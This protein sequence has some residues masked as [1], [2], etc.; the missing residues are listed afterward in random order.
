MKVYRKLSEFKPQAKAI[1]T[2]GTFDGV[3]IGHQKLLSTINDLAKAEDGES[4]LLTFSPHPRLVLFPEDNDLKL[5]STLDE[6]IERLRKSGLD[7]LIV[8][9]FTIDFS[10]ITA[11]DYVSEILVNQLGV[12]KLVIGYDHHFG[13]NREGNLEYLKKVAPE[14][15]FEIVEIPAQEIDDV[16][17]SSTKIRKALV[18]GKVSLANE[19]LGYEYGIDGTV[20][21]GNKIGR[22]MGFPT[23]NIKPLDKYKLVPGS[24]V[25]AVLFRIDDVWYKGMAN[26]GTRP[27]VTNSPKSV[28]EVNVFNFDGDLYGKKVRVVFVSRLRNEVKFENM[29][30]LAKQ[31]ENDADNTEMALADRSMDFMD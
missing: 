31:M 22:T 30:E 25:Y 15:G 14:C 29:A 20:V 1:V 5:L 28:I 12:H 13:R 10:R 21:N 2:V 7:H 4:V 6:R 23:A 19:Y 27:T 9:P 18:E 24:G 3:H 17:V 8:H 16:N 11:I 26:I